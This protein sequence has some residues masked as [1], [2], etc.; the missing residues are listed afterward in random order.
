MSLDYRP[1]ILLACAAGLALVLTEPVRAADRSHQIVFKKTTPG[2]EIWP[3]IREAIFG[4]N[5]VQVIAKMDNVTVA[6]TERMLREKF[7]WT[8]RFDLNEDGKDELFVL[9]YH[10]LT[11]GT[12]GCVG[13]VLEQD[14][15]GWRRLSP[16][17]LVHIYTDRPT[18]LKLRDSEREDYYPKSDRR[19]AKLIE[20]YGQAP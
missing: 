9:M 19:K 12:M 20:K 10:S 5:G 4:D 18:I 2:G 6:Q 14:A 7:T 11:C 8:A 13:E 17:G 3:A 15:N 16:I 1:A